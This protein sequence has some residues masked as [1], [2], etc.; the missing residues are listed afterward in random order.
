[1]SDTL[2]QLM[3]LAM[4]CKKAQ[5]PFDVFAF[6]N[7]FARS[8]GH[9]FYHFDDVQENDIGIIKN[10]S[11]MHLI[12][13]TLK[14]SAFNKSMAYVMYMKNM[15]VS[16]G[17]YSWS[18]TKFYP[19]PNSLG[20][21][22][23]PLN[24]AIIAAMEVVPTFQKKNNVQIVNTIFLTDGQGHNTSSTYSE[25]LFESTGGN[26][27]IVDPVTKKHYKS[28]IG[29]KIL[30]EILK[31]RTGTTLAG[32][33]I[34]TANKRGFQNDLYYAGVDYDETTTLYNKM[35]KDGFCVVENAGYDEFYILS[36]KNLRVDDD[37]IEKIKSDMTKN[38]MKNVF[39]SAQKGKIANKKML[40]QFAELVA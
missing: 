4:F 12:S 18:D 36:S 31:D 8:G 29:D 25:G 34:T 9:T 7:N 20:L 35:K 19:M 23:T 30:L 38:K 26:P 24:E 6:T 33:F 21:G 5:I 2:D 15:F 13:S 37:G 40:S 16:R 32:F 3:M 1:M 10:F 39:I 22:G 17:S 28:W 14:T 27:T 11:L